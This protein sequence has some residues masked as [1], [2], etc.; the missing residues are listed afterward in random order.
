[1]ADSPRSGAQQIDA[2]AI[3]RRTETVVLILLSLVN[4]VV[5]LDRLAVNFL[6]PFIVH[7]LGLNNT[8]LGLLSSA[9]SGA[10]AIS[11]LAFSAWA[12][13]TGRHKGVL[14][15]VLVAFSLLSGGA[16]IAT[17]FAMLFAARLLLGISEGPLIPIAQTVMGAASH[18][19]RRGF[20]MGAMQM[21]GAFL[22][23]AMLGPLIMVR[24]AEAMGWQ[25]AF[26]VSAV[27]G[28]LIAALVAAFVPNM[29]ALGHVTHGA[30]H[31]EPPPSIFA[32][33]RTRN[34][35]ICMAIAAIFTAWLTIQNVFMPRY[36]TE[37]IGHSADTM[38][39]LLSLSGFGG[40][41]GGF[42]LPALSDRFGRKPLA[43]VGGFSGMLVP[44]A[45]LVVPHNGVLLGALLAL[46]GMTV[47][48]APLI[49]AVVPSESV[50]PARVATAVAMSFSSAELLGG[51]CSPPIAGWA[52]DHWGLRAPFYLD[53]AC[54][55]ICGL[56]ALALRETA[57]RRRSV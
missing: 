33:L 10:I 26:F 17:G 22:I 3:S 51:M 12:D 7:D 56:L 55:I 14:V 54:A 8:Q 30:A 52:A 41:A 9:L 19:P 43:I 16:G 50:A 35:A 48:Y 11:G 21:T 44:V 36:L 42:I 2:P 38:S 53:F 32:L 46:G 6:S 15:W 20:N 13:R 37:T 57:P 39:W 5:A 34:L 49:L 40:L 23:G 28:L 25:H 47:G 29:Q 1:M 4:G 45:L 24:L 31:A 27:P 18:P